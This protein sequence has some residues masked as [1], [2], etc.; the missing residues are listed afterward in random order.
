[1]LTVGINSGRFGLAM[2]DDTNPGAALVAARSGI[3]DGFR[4]EAASPPPTSAF[5]PEFNNGP[6]GSNFTIPLWLPLLA[7]LLPTLLLWYVDRRRFPPG[8]CR[9]GYNLTGLTSGRCPEC[10]AAA[11]AP[12]AS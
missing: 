3:P 5:W 6:W 9:C 4:F 7:L 12:A 10:G 11:T 8:H 1:L 2:L